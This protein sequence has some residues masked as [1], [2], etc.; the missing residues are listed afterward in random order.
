V[1]VKLVKK[2][3]IDSSSQLEKIRMEIDILK[4][5]IRIFSRRRRERQTNNKQNHHITFVHKQQTLNHPYIVKLLS[6]N[7]TNTN[8]GM[9][10]EYAQGES[11]RYMQN[12]FCN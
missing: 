10:L 11:L 12:L 8:I 4:V 9:V 2:Q 5:K 7:E 6:V 1:A 3:N